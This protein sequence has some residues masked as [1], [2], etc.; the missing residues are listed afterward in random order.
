MVSVEKHCDGTA[1]GVRILWHHL[2]NHTEHNMGLDT[3]KSAS[4]DL[5]PHALTSHRM[6]CRK[7]CCPSPQL[8]QTLSCL[9]FPPAP[10][11]LRFPLNSEE[12][13]QA[14]LPAAWLMMTGTRERD[15]EK[16]E[17]AL[18]RGK[19]SSSQE[20]VSQVLLKFGWAFWCE[21]SHHNP[22]SCDKQVRLV[23][24]L[25]ES[26]ETILCNWKTCLVPTKAFNQ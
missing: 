6:T 14:L 7:V 4:C 8:T 26:L 24:K 3:I 18:S 16:K 22:S 11:P 23:Q 2:E 20:L 19:E 25:L 9:A 12:D 17:E 1:L 10:C 13:D 5:A 21:L 15:I